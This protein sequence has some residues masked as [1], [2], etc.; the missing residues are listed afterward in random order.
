MKQNL[1]LINTYEAYNN[2]MLRYKSHLK[3][4]VIGK[5]GYPIPC[6]LTIL[7]GDAGVGKSWNTEAVFEKQRIRKFVK[8]RVSITTAGLYQMMWENPDA[9][10]MLDD[11]D[12]ILKDKKEGIPLLKACTDTKG[13]R[14]LKRYNAGHNCVHVSQE[15]GMDNNDKIKKYIEKKCMD[16]DKKV[17]LQKY[18][19]YVP[20]MFFF[21]GAL[22]ILTNMSLYEL[23]RIMPDRGISSRAWKD[24]FLF[25]IDGAIDLVKH[26]V[27]RMK[28]FNDETLK[29]INIRKAVSFLTNKKARKHYSDN[30]TIPSL[31][32][33]GYV[34]LDYQ[35]GEKVDDDTLHHYT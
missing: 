5:K 3:N 1:R 14:V 9:V 30:N 29:K 13:V 27:D 35:H 22:I 23:D 17:N 7:C 33:V 12:A 18:Q 32:T 15:R 25:S 2:K 28:N 20:D 21:T 6:H 11:V 16:E 26:S 4:M 19:K 31:R 24:E 34:A 8:Q 10:I